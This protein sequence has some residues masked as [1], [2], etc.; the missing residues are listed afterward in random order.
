MAGGEGAPDLGETIGNLLVN[1]IAITVFAVL[2]KGESEQSAATRQK[3]AREEE[4]G[5]LRLRLAEDAEDATVSRLRGNY[6]LFLVAGSE[7]HIDTVVAGLSKYKTLLKEKNVVS[8]RWTWRATAAR[9]LGERK[10]EPKGRGVAALAAEF[11]AAREQS[12]EDDDAAPAAPA[13]AFGKRSR[14][15]KP[16][17]ARAFAGGASTPTER[18]WRVAPAGTEVARVG[19]ERD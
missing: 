11:A 6:R 13:L 12:A 1:L 3:V 17:K 7:A 19:G 15:A 18:K 10:R 5:R 8:R 16:G 2:F 4:F 9:A 14:K